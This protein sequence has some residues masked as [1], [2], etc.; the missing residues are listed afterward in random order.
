MTGYCPDPHFFR[1]LSTPLGALKRRGYNGELEATPPNC[2]AN[3][4]FLQLTVSSISKRLNA[5]PEMRS[6]AKNRTR[7]KLSG[8]Q[9]EYSTEKREPTLSAS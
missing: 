6:T 8:R 7:L 1:I 3:L 9:P 5:L 4:A 2:K